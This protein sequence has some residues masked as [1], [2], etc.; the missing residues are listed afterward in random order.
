MKRFIVLITA[1]FLSIVS[2][3]Q[4]FEQAKIDPVTFDKVKVK[5]GADFAIQLQM[6]DHEADV[7]LIDLK[8]NFNL[9]TANLSLTTDLAPGIQLYMN[10]YLSSRHHNEAWVEGGYLIIDN[11]PFLPAANNI[12]KYLTIKAGVMM[13]DYGDAHYF[14]S[15]NAAVLNNPFVGNWVM[16]AF[17]TNPG[18]EVMFRNNG[19]LALVGAN[20]GRMNYGRGG[21]LGEDLVFNWKLGY[22]K[23]I[24]EDL[25][26][27]ATLSGYHVGEGHSGSYLWAGDRAGARYYNVM[28]TAAAE[29]DNFRSG[30]WDPNSG[31]SEMNSYMANVF[32]QFHGL[33]VFGI[34]ENMKGVRRD[35]DQHFTQTAVQALYRLGSFYLGTRYNHVSDNDGSEVN[36]TNIGGG[37]FMTNNVL[38]K[39]DYVNQ[40][41]DGPAHGEIDGGKFNGVVLEAAISF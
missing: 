36:R 10:T 2:F 6:L 22:D 29:A 20:N 13:P 5:V 41:Y 4:Q 7:E 21:D 35:A 15:N 24:N 37:W 34:Y 30:R 32:V 26:V 1:A 3:G 25:R 31:Q 16:D 18:L 33:E 8:N 9:P 11:M 38:V 14:R 27:R 19:F 23:N 39:L 28:Q 40:K 17:T 12:M